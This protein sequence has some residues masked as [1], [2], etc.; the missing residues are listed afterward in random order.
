V[1]GLLL[2]AALVAGA[3][4]W[5][6]AA[7]GDVLVFAAA[8]LKN[9][10]DE[11][12]TA[13]DQEKGSRVT[14]SYAAA[15]AL[16][17]QI[18]QGA[19]AQLF[20]SADLDWMDYVE[21]RGLIAKDSRGNLLGNSLVLIAGKDVATGEV[22]LQ[23]GLD[24]APLLGEGRLAVGDVKAVPAGKYAKAALENL[25]AWTAVEGRLAQ[26]ESV[27]AAL[28]LVSRGEAPLGIVYRTDAA[29]DPNV[30]IVGSFPKGSHPPIIYPA[31]LTVNAGAPAAAFLAYLQTSP[32][33]RAAFQK[34]GFTV[35]GAPAS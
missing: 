1:A 33:A 17:K 30:R 8:S 28:A 26:A 4:A 10:L 24:L 31:A 23:P 20:I 32:A 3:P 22:A 29:A 14:A 34:Q 35:L 27:R 18:E 2:A 19:P 6:I 21:Q 16:A 5:A 25:G 7:D 11:I 15:S 13:Y 12:M 9:A